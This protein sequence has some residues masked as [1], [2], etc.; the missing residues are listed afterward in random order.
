MSL[1]EVEPMTQMIETAQRLRMVRAAQRRFL[2]LW[3]FEKR[4]NQSPQ[5]RCGTSSKRRES[6]MKSLDLSFRQLRLF[7]DL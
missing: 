3:E 5:F 6:R 2:L 1:E 4:E 7:D